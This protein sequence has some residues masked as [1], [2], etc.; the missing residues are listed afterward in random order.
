MAPDHFLGDGMS[1][2]PAHLKLAYYM[3]ANTDQKRRIEEQM[4]HVQSGIERSMSHQVVRHRLISDSRRIKQHQPLQ[5]RDPSTEPNQGQTTQGARS[6]EPR[7]RNRVP[8]PHA[9]GRADSPEEERPRGQDVT[10]CC[11]LMSTY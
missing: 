4:K 7:K 3:Y 1:H 9:K 8:P 11:L 6:K 10:T 2:R 5:N